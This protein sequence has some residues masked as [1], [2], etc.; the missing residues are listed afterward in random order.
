MAAWAAVALLA[1]ASFAQSKGVVIKGKAPVNNQALK[2]KLPKAYQTTL[3]S[4]MQVI[5]LENHK[6]PT[7]SMQM[8]V[9]SGGFA[10]PAGQ[11]GTAQYVATMLREGTKTRNSKQIAEA[12][13]SLG[14]SLNAGASLSSLTSTISAAGLTD[15]FDAIME[16]FADVILNP[17][18]PKEDF[19]KMKSRGIAQLRLA[20]SQPNFLAGEMF[21]RAMYGSHPGGRFSLNAE[22]ISRFTP[23]MLS[24]FH[25]AHYKP[26]NA[27][28]AIVGD[29]K[30]A[31]IVAKLEK[32]FAGWKRGDVPATVVPP[33]AETGP[34]QIRLIDRPGSVQTN[35]ILGVQ[36]IERNDP[37][38]YALDVLNQIVGGGA[39]ARLFL[40]LREDKGYTYGAYSNFNAS[41]YRGLYRAATEV[42]T[43]VTKESVTELMYE[44]KRIRDEKV[45]REEFDRAK[46]T[47]VGS[48]ALQLESPQSLLGNIITAKLHGLPGDYWDTYPAKIAAITEDEVQRVA[49]KYLDLGKL[50][51]V[52]VGDASKI[53]DVL[54]QFGS[55]EIFDTEGKPARPAPPEAPAPAGSSATG[56]GISGNWTLN[57]ETPNG[58]MPLKAVLKQNGDQLAGTLDTPFGQFSITNGSVKGADVSFKAKVDVQGN[59][60][61]IEAIGKLDGDTMKGQ[62]NSAVMPTVNFTGKKEK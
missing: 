3:A 56:P 15:Q 12:V 5:V 25:A 11:E 42:R 46:R 45:P 1:G 30:P 43:E 60:M 6:L 38:Y 54:K 13:D 27:I 59:Q 21:S 9:L 26:N 8:V 48:F 24:A 57:V 32:T 55:V 61:E 14:A 28:F 53:A 16:L 58:V 52:A 40:N 20:R 2:V 50:Q 7:F 10:D 4:G 49:R 17:T 36:T 23:E 37:D 29:V 22:Q 51:T 35:L 39:S 19:D 44:I 47:I 34:A 18:F 31:E 41:R 33:V 62:L